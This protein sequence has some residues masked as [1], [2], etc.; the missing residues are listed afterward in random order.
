V[1]LSAV[2]AR[3]D[4]AWVEWA[5]ARARLGL[6]WSGK[7]ELMLDLAAPGMA[8]KYWTQAEGSQLLPP[9]P[10]RRVMSPI[11]G[12]AAHQSAPRPTYRIDQDGGPESRSVA[13]DGTQMAGQG[14]RDARA[15]GGATVVLDDALKGMFYA[16][17][18]NVAQF[19]ERAPECPHRW[20]VAIEQPFLEFCQ[21]R[22]S[23]RYLRFDRPP[24]IFFVA[25]R[26][27]MLGLDITAGDAAV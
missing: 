6:S 9:G 20:R 11:L 14:P 4:V 27:T 18:R 23:P 7:M 24:G 19:W 15:A 2:R 12:D 21:H 22:L 1:R 16:S 10:D 5:T 3:I 13:D 17:G 8:G 25:S 26:T